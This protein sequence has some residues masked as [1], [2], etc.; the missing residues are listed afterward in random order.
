MSRA[1]DRIARA[2]RNRGAAPGAVVIGGDYQGLGIVRSLGRRGI[3]VL[4][5]DDERSIS[6]HSRFATAAVHVPEL[7]DEETVVATLL[8]LGERYGLEGWVVFPTREETVAALS[9][10]RERL[11]S[12]FRIPTPPWDVVRWAWDKRNTYDIATE[13]GIATPRTWSV[14][15][16]EELDA[17]DGE[18]PF[19]V[20]PAIKERF[21]YATGHKAW[22]ANTRAEL[23]AR[24]RAAADLVGAGEVVV[25]ELIPGSGEAQL[26]YCAFFRD[27]RSSASMVARRLRQ[28]P[29]LF[30][31]AS[32]FVETVQHPEL[33]E[34]SER[35]LRRIGY[36]GLVELEYK[37]DARD[38]RTKLLDVNART[39]GYHSLGQCAG[40]DFPYLLYADQLS[41]PALDGIRA[42]PGV[43]WIRLATDVPMAAI[44]L[45]RG[46]LDWRAYVRSL[47]VA[48]VE[49]VFSRDDPLPGLAELA[50]L[51]YL[52]VKRGF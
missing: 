32:T 25:Q 45:A 29:P 44:E 40:V 9:R 35:F 16:T 28:H 12:Q 20:K 7:R 33:E 34:L 24:F 43:S 30:G 8:G 22:R 36:Y 48:N 18:P 1:G 23:D 50:L 26:A 52:A 11:L 46:A 38:G 10:H 27:G 37:H 31:R 13:L 14:G 49:S 5:I 2:L 15:S 19:A 42:T 4:V 47:L 41:L 21:L 3:D 6:R 39:W 51:P 17:I